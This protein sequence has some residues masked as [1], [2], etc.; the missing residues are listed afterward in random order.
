MSRAQRKID[1]PNPFVFFLEKLF[2]IDHF[3]QLK[4]PFLVIESSLCTDNK[5]KKRQQ[6]QTKNQKKKK[7]KKI[8]F[9]FLPGKKKK[10]APFSLFN[11]ICLAKLSP[12]WQAV[13]FHHW[14]W[15]E[16]VQGNRKVSWA[17]LSNERNHIKI[18]KKNMCAS[19]NLAACNKKA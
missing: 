19:H 6:Q 4:R 2:P 1:I 10:F 17:P 8:I 9:F 15:K 7:Q 14:G 13:S 12:K 3:Q 11:V 5:K 16:F 18:F